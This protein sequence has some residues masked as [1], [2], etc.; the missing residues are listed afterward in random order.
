MSDDITDLDHARNTGAEW[1]RQAALELLRAL[2][3]EEEPKALVQR[4]Q[5]EVDQLRSKIDAAHGITIGHEWHHARHERTRGRAA[6]VPRRKGGSMTKEDRAL[7][8]RPASGRTG[9]WCL[10]AALALRRG[11]ALDLHAHGCP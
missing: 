4:L 8:R 5:A 9:C 1:G 7:R 11:L 10:S 3:Q 6:P 2:E